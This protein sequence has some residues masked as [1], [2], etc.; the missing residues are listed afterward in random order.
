MLWFNE[1][2]GHGFIRTE[3]EE[4]L[5][6]ERAGFSVGH[7]P[8]DRCKGLAVEFERTLVGEDARATGVVFITPDEQRRARLRHARSGRGL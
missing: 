2:K 1:D 7:A 8:P 3:D 5:C 6:V 4:R